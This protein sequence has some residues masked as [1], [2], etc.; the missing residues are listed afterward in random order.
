MTKHAEG[1]SHESMMAHTLAH[2]YN[3]SAVAMI[4]VYP[5][6]TQVAV[7]LH[8]AIT[9][10]DEQVCIAQCIRQGAA[11]MSKQLRERYVDRVPP[12]PPLRV[13]RRRKDDGGHNGH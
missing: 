6:G 13:V 5:D 11:S 1:M 9:D 3:A 4:I 12:P 7:Q 10:P 2:T 8:C